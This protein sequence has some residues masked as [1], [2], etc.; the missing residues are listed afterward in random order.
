MLPDEGRPTPV[1]Y[2]PPSG[3]VTRRSFRL[4]LILTSIN[5][6]LLGAVV[7]GPGLTP[8]VRQQWADLQRRQADRK[9]EATKAVVRHALLPAQKQCMDYLAP[10]GT[11]LYAE[12][13]DGIE[14]LQAAGPVNFICVL[15]TANR[16][17]EM[18]LQ[19]V[20]VDNPAFT[21]NMP[22]TIVNDDDPYSGGQLLH[23][24]DTTVV[25]LH[26]RKNVVG[27]R[28]IVV[29]VRTVQDVTPSVSNSTNVT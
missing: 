24:N 12:D 27:V 20:G 26:Q 9:S 14:K 21:A 19:P 13:P 18:R 17:P 1:A 28:L 10:A 25:F 8:F 29:Y 16:P 22:T 23:H 11:L 6:M 15:T 3:G 5:T 4:L 7:L 2:E